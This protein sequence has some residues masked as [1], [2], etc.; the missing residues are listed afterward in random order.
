E[1]L[2]LDG[3]GPGEAYP[4]AVFAIELKVGHAPPDGSGR[5]LARLQCGEVKDRLDFD[6]SA[7]VAGGR[8][9]TGHELS[10]REARR[11]PG[12]RVFDGARELR[13]RAGQIVERVEIPL[14]TRQSESQGL[15]QAAPV[16]VGYQDL[17]E[18]LRLAKLLRG[19]VDLFRGEEQ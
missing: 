15:H 1:L 13:Q 2:V 19:G 6:D 9:L 5:C 18:R 17:D 14:D 10:P 16:L 12:D 7:Q 11:T 3:H 8:R 4:R